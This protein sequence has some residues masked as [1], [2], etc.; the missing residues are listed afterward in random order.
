[1]PPFDGAANDSSQNLKQAANQDTIQLW[2][3]ELA[4]DSLP[5]LRSQNFSSDSLH[6]FNLVESSQVMAG[7][8]STPSNQAVFRNPEMQFAYAMQDAQNNSYTYGNAAG[9]VP[10]D[11][12]LVLPPQSEVP[13]P[14][15]PG[16]VSAANVNAQV[17]DSQSAQSNDSTTG[18]IGS[19]PNNKYGLDANYARGGCS[20]GGCGGMGGGLFN[21]FGGGGG[22]FLRSALGLGAGIGLMSMLF[23]GGGIGGGGF[24]AMLPLMLLS[25]GMG[26]FGGLGGFGGMGG[27]GGLMRMMFMLPFLF[28]AFRR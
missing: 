28:S 5:A 1:M 7:N 24:G 19:V 23:R 13:P 4:A 10:S 14:P 2:S 15:Q 18:N 6:P 22:G 21:G 27:G 11:L 16:D 3:G 26:G 9:Q 8:E 17:D 20:G 12:P 25:G